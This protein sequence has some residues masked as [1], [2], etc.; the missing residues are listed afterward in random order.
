[1]E[2]TF[3]KIKDIPGESQ[4]D[5]PSLK[6]TIP[7]KSLEWGVE[8]TVDLADLGTAQRGYANSQ[9]Q[10]VKLTSDMNKASMKLAQAV[11]N[12]TALGTVEIYMCRSGA[13]EKLAMEV[14]LTFKLYDCVIDG[15]DMSGGEES[16]PSENWTLAYRAIEI[17]YKP[18]VFTGGK[19][20]GKLGKAVPFS[21]D[22]VKGKPK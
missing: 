18:S 20:S 13:D 21:W 4:V 15:Y 6:D 10:K 12:G 8:R 7:V 22:L 5:Q 3:V 2:N 9:F 16:V 14:Y 11:S 19:D 17:E 1:M